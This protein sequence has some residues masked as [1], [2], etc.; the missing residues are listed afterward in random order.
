[1]ANGDGSTL[2]ASKVAPV[3]MV[4]HELATNAAK[5]GAWSRPGGCVAVAWQRTGQGELSLVW[6]ETGGPELSGT[7]ARGYGLGLI[8][9]VIGHE[10]EGRAELDFAATGL[11]CRLHIPLA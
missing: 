3:T 7:P 4:L 1:V 9:G 2:I 10:L 6:R 8:E 11:N 5:Y